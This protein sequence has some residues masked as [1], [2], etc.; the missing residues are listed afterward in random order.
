MRVIVCQLPGPG[1]ATLSFFFF[2][3][4]GYG[5]KCTHSIPQTKFMLS[6]IR[7]FHDPTPNTNLNSIQLVR[8][9]IEKCI[10]H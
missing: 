9:M 7:P 4:L 6:M 8:I 1:S 5:G 10:G 2:F 3:F